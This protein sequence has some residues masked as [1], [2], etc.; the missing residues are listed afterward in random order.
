MPKPNH[1]WRGLRRAALLSVTAALALVL[2]AT[3]ASADNPPPIPAS[4]NWQT[5][6]NFYRAMAGLAGVG[7]NAVW[8]DGDFKHSRYMAE[9]DDVQHA[10]NPASPWYTPEGNL[11]AQNG[12]IYWG[13]GS[14]A[15]SCLER[16][17]VEFWMAGPFHAVA[18]V[19][20]KLQT[21]GFGTYI[22]QVNNP[23]T[24][25][26]A[27]LDVLRGRTGA[28]AGPIKFPGPGM[29]TPVLSYP[30]FESPDPLLGCGFGAPSGPA[31]VLMLTAT[32]PSAA[33]ATLKDNGTTVN[34][35]VR[36]EFSRGELAFRHAIYVM[37]QFPLVSAHAYAVDITVGAT[38]YAW[39]FFACEAGQTGGSCNV[40]T[41]VAVRTASAV[42]TRA[43]VFV[44][45][46]TASESQTLGF[47]VYRVRQGKL[48]KL[49]RALIASVFGGTARGHAY[50]W[51]DRTA[52]RATR[53]LAYRLQAVGL[54]GTRRWVGRAST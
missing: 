34:A 49:N 32:P 7:E 24:R 12:N 25:C 9:T 52:P 17:S 5:T 39:T 45:W 28:A 44:R 4:A 18:I 30:G 21:S 38:H 16:K 35:C 3:P 13:F 46:R 1:V 10:E 41:A 8:S 11:A 51:L 43:G 54:D 6:V 19:D 48:V 23:G 20:P 26:G 36:D 22:S 31:I 37:P 27:T 42:R 2:Y 40:P 14:P 15:V 47:N 29:T 50:S 33:T 53:T